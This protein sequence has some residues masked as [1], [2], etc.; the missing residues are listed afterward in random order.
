MKSYL[1]D[2]S[3]LEDDQHEQCEKRVV[4]V[5]VEAPECDAEDL[6]DEE[7]RSRMFPK[8]LQERGDRDVELVFTEQA[9]ELL[10]VRRTKPGDR[11]EAA[12]R[13]VGGGRVR[14]AFER[15]GRV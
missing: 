10:D 12:E 2:C 15:D 1:R 7:R 11:G 3:A 4:P 9:L 5:L 6:E 8:E 14:E 13:W